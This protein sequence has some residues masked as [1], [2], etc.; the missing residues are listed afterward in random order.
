MS[1]AKSLNALEAQYQYETDEELKR[2]RE[3]YRAFIV[4]QTRDQIVEQSANLDYNE[5]A[6]EVLSK[7]VHK[8]ERAKARR[9]LL[10]EL[11][12]WAGLVGP[13]I[14]GLFASPYFLALW[15]ALVHIAGLN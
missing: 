14:V 4:G 5:K 12:M 10:K 9:A 1:N 2:K 13:F 11:M 7:I 6:Y 15:N 8:R 3:V